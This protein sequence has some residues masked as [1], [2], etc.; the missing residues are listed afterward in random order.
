MENC[1]GGR[2]S[3]YDPDSQFMFFCYK[4]DDAKLSIRARHEM[5]HAFQQHF[6]ALHNDFLYTTP[7]DPTKASPSEK[8][9]IENI[10]GL[11]EGTAAAAEELGET[12]S[13]SSILKRDLHP[14][15]VA[16]TAS[17]LFD[18]SNPPSHI[19][20]HTQDFWVYFGLKNKLGL[21]YLKPLFD[22]G[23]TAAAVDQFFIEEY[24]TS[25]GAEYWGWVKNQA[26]EKTI[27]FNGAV[28]LCALPLPTAG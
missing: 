19:E 4:R 24:G 23:A 13:R 20:H 16:L 7:L 8:A 6:T 5:F 15:N 22:R 17:E 27:D 2:P 3:E 1:N 10:N 14:I 26:I 18:G 12:M 11:S 25:L 21:A 28:P 9:A